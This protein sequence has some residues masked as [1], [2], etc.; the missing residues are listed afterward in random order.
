MIARLAPYFVLLQ[1][2]VDRRL[3]LGEFEAIYLFLFKNDPGGLQPEEYEILNDLFGKVD[4]YCSDVD[5]RAATTDGIGPDE[6]LAAIQLTLDK[7][8][9]RGV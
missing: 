6:L 9:A 2:C 8:V 4:A 5:L 1:A 3:S 7:L